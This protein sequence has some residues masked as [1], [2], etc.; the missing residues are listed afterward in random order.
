VRVTTQGGPFAGVSSPVIHRRAEKMLAHLGLGDVELSVALVDDAIIHE[1]N[2]SY[3][4]K[5]KPTDV[6]AFPL[7]D[8]VPPEPGSGLL[9]DVIV[10]VDTARKQA[11]R[12]RRSL[13]DEMTM[14]LAHGLLHL[15]GHD[16]QT[17]A[18]EREMTARTRELEAAAA[19]RRPA[20]TGISP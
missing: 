16:H 18:Q 12:H 11:K 10:S 8:L 2:R 15:L 5:D 6:L 9:G 3:R 13:L 20:H 14:L 7:Q 17:D 19:A 4:H 1:L